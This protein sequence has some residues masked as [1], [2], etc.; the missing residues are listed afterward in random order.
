MKDIQFTS[1]RTDLK[2]FVV[3]VCVILLGFVALPWLQVQYHLRA[4]HR[5]Q[6]PPR[7]MEALFKL[8]YLQETEIP[9]QHSVL[10]GAVQ[11]AFFRDVQRRIPTNGICWFGFSSNRT[12]VIVT[13]EKTET[14]RW[15]QLVSDFDA[16]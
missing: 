12:S 14:A 10:T 3:L 4:L 6:D 9:F 11:Q 5:N 1:R 15:R 7:Q 2:I 16:R 8:G 13:C